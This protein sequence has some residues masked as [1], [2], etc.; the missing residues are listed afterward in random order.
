MQSLSEAWQ[1]AIGRVGFI[2]AAPCL[3]DLHLF[4]STLPP[5]R[6]AH[7]AAQ[8]LVAQHNLVPLALAALFRGL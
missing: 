4:T 7:T 3:L 8:L 6:H 1:Q 5:A 2:D